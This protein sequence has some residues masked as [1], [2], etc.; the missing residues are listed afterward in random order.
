MSLFEKFSREYRFISKCGGSERHML[1]RSVI[2]QPVDRGVWSAWQNTNGQCS[3][4]NGV[5]KLDTL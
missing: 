5:W 4:V 2:H 3:I 1:G